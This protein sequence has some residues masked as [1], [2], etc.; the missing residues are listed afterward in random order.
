MLNKIAYFK[1]YICKILY[2]LIVGLLYRNKKSRKIHLK[3]WTTKLEKK[4]LQRYLYVIQHQEQPDYPCPKIIWICWLQGMENAPEVVKIC[5]RSIQ[6]YCP[7]FEIRTITLKNLKE[8]I[9]FPDF[10]WKKY[11]NK[12]ISNTQFSDLL[13][14]SL[15]HKYG[16][17]WIDSTVYLTA[18][19]PQK[20]QQAQYFSFHAE[21]HLKN[22]N[23][24]IKAAAG[25]LLIKNMQ[26]LMF[27][28]WKYENRLI[29]YFLYHL[30]FDLMIE[31][32]K[33]LAQ[34]WQ[35]FPIIYDNCYEL[36]YSFFKPYS[37]NKWQEIK[38]KTSI[39]K[40]SY[41]YKKNKNFT[42]TFLEKLLKNELE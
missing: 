16:G 15:L 34:Y 13:R 14:L 21:T 11:Q 7:E 25:N 33:D 24:F 8:Y 10:I 5:Y 32:N 39:H 36:E 12:Q 30:F 4:Y 6:K 29:N 27:E 26:N 22:N 9:S 31:K 3:D 37:L 23:W 40:L 42:G 19:I 20:I 2:R 17:Y 41:K 1:V 28:Y 38:Q 18:P 35:Q